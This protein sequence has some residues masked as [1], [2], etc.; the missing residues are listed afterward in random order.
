MSKTTL[1]EVTDLCIGYDGKSILDDLCFSITSGSYLCVVGENGT[2]KSTLLK[3][4][5]GLLKPIYGTVDF[6]VSRREI[7]YLPQQTAIQHDFPASAKEIVSSGAL[8][9][10]KWYRPFLSKEEKEQIAWACEKTGVSSFENQCFRELSGGQQQRVLLAR[11]MVTAKDAVIMDEPTAGLDPEAMKE[12]N[13]LLSK[14]NRDEK[15]TII[16]VTHDVESALE[17]ASHI[18]HLCADSTKEDE[19]ESEEFFFCEAN[20]YQ[21]KKSMI[22]DNL[23]R[24]RGDSRERS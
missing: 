11:A 17:N 23:K 10:G 5:S 16:M 24:K 2:G 13:E 6:S 18:L 14:L 9:R 7:G 4:I 8:S 19:D 3:T 1:L 12:F 15:I 20:E 21:E 22:Q